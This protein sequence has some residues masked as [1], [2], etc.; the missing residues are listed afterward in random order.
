MYH[1]NFFY[2]LKIFIHPLKIFY[3]RNFSRAPPN[4]CCVP[5]LTPK[6][7][8]CKPKKVGVLTP[9]I[10]PTS[11]T[12]GK[13][14]GYNIYII[15]VVLICRCRIRGR[16]LSCFNA[17]WNLWTVI[18]VRNFSKVTTHRGLLSANSKCEPGITALGNIK[19][20]FC[21]SSANQNDHRITVDYN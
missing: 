1:L 19:I 4:F 17:M 14:V 5:S 6:K 18:E 21:L 9:K 8:G 2:T 15:Y 12:L 3:L 7:W 11:A 10:P 20:T 16:D 13:G